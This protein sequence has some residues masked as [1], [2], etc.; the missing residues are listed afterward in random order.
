M[1]YLLSAGIP[2]SL[3][4]GSSIGPRS[5]LLQHSHGDIQLKET[6][7][8]ENIR[9]YASQGEHFFYQP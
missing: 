9:V 1:P 7:L 2:L 3:M 5:A 4:K 6:G 8:K